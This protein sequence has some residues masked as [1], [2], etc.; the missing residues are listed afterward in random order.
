MNFPLAIAPEYAEYSTLNGYVRCWHEDRI[1]LQI[2]WL[3]AYLATF[4]IK[5][6]ES[7]L[8]STH[9]RDDDLPLP[10][11]AGSLNQH[12]VSANNVLVAH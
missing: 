6:L 10:C 5:A 7:R 1:H 8:R 4:K 9:K 3:Q 12:I 11:G 2:G